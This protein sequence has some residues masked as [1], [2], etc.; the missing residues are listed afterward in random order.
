MN[1]VSEQR[2]EK[3]EVAIIGARMVEVVSTAT[4]PKAL[5]QIAASLVRANAAAGKWIVEK[6]GTSCRTF[7]DG[8]K[9]GV[10]ANIDG[11]VGSPDACR[12]SK[13][14]AGSGTRVAFGGINNDHQRT[15]I[16]A[17]LP[18]L[19]PKPLRQPAP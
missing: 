12:E 4:E 10:G 15:Y 9:A 3:S 2:V 8:C 6:L 11:V 19:S 14:S 5:P 1:F 13:S 7:N 17:D 16:I 18:S